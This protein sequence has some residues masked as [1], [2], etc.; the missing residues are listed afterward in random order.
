MAIETPPIKVL[1]CDPARREPGLLYFTTR[2][3]GL[4][5]RTQAGWVIAVDRDG[6]FA[7]QRQF[8]GTSQ[9][10]RCQED[11]S[12]LFSQSAQS[13]LHE[14]DAKG[15]PRRTW[16]ARGIWRGKTPPA[17]STELP[18]DF[19]HHTVNI[20]PNGNLLILD[21][22]QRELPDWPTSSNDPC[23][24]RVTAKVIGDIVTEVTR[25]GRLVHAHRIFDILDPYRITHGS[26]SGY[27]R[28][29]G[30]PDSYDWSHANAVAYD[31]HDDSF[32]VSLRHQ[33]C[34]IKLDRVTGDLKWILG[35]SSGW[36]A[37]W[38]LKLLKPA[39]GLAWQ[40]HQHDCSVTGPNRIMCFDNGC[41]R[42]GA[43]EAPMED[44]KSYSRAVEFEV[45]EKAKTVRQ[46][47]S[48][49]EQRSDK[50]FACYQGGAR[51]LPKTG[52]T[53][54]TF[55]GMCFENGHPSNTNIG[56]FGKARL[57]EVTPAGDVVLDIAVDDS[58]SPSPSPWSAF[59]ADHMP[60]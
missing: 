39:A 5:V 12:V 37:P 40:F 59:R 52:N 58:N 60:G 34:I 2:P 20:L 44:A 19:I 41:F 46:V 29:Q 10:I 31:P 25:D 50:L 30:F 57:I 47:W 22:E 6:T 4:P 16:H 11:G 54:I 14:L 38:T 17:G 23:A 32:V 49:G 3:G 1:S 56:T 9:D 53:F 26:L 36:R 15:N 13:L 42:A 18:V 28:K 35:N 43:F 51:R 7:L 33:D 24:P 21:A 45:D 55:G 48:Y 8:E 27:W